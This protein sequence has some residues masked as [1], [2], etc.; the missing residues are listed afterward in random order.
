MINDGIKNIYAKPVTFPIYQTS[1]YIVPEGEKYRY[2]REYNPTVEN[3]GKEIMRI[4]GSEDYNVFSSVNIR[5]EGPAPLTHVDMAFPS[6]A[7]FLMSL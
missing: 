2:T 6:M 5:T 4:E 7:L 1:S 3:L